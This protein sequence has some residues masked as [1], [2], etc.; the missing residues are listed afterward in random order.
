MVF[1]KAVNRRDA[2]RRG[3]IIYFYELPVGK[4]F[5]KYQVG[6]Q[7]IFARQ[8]P[9]YVAKSGHFGQ[10][11]KIVHEGGVCCLRINRGRDGVGGEYFLTAQKRRGLYFNAVGACFAEKDTG[12]IEN[13]QHLGREAQR[14]HIAYAA[15]RHVEFKLR[16]K[17]NCVHS[18][19]L[20]S[21][22]FFMKDIFPE[23]CDQLSG[24][25]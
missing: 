18:G 22:L 10:I 1:E 25:A 9:G 19:L 16:L 5:I 23:S 13:F 7:E 21:N 6:V 24:F 11:D 20:E 2:A 15:G 17:G 3:F 4:L 14:L 8:Q 12:D